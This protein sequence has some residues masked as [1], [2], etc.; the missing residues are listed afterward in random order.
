MKLVVSF[1]PHGQATHTLRCYHLTWLVAALVPALA[2]L[3]F[4][5]TSA[6]A[7]LVLTVLTSVLTEV[8]CDRI[9]GRATTVG[10]GHAALM[11]LLFGLTLSPAVPWWLAIV[12]SMV[13]IVMGKAMFGGLG[14][15]AFHPV[16]VA[17][18]VCY[19]SWPELMTTYVL[20]NPGDL[21]GGE[22]KEAIR[23]YLAIRQDPALIG[24]FEPLARFLG[25]SY[26]GP[27]GA[28]SGLAVVIGGAFLFFRGYLPP[29]IP[30]AFLAAVAVT[31]QAYFLADPTC[32]PW[33]F[34]L[35]SGTVLLA[36]LLLAP[37]PTTSPVTVP[38]WVVFGLGI[39]LT[40]MIFRI[41]GT[42]PEAAFYAILIFNSLT[43][44]LD[45]IK[46]TPFGAA[47][48]KG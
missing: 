27:I 33:H 17:W 46:P 34:H 18:V 23:P 45:R 32:G 29:A 48:I 4:Y 5:G 22:I 39:G 14:F 16:L 31:S 37:E 41:H 43:P 38:G 36:A 12:G 9:A 44:I 20:P 13:M 2:G 47:S 25:G 35:L 24:T 6:L 19:L 21:S 30:G 8:V 10:D 15:Y 40:T 11:G 42:R 28:S 1:P 26:A 3:C 7:V